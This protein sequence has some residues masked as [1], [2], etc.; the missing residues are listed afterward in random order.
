MFSKENITSI[1]YVFHT[2]GMLVCWAWSPSWQAGV[3]VAAHQLSFA[4]E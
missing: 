1:M 4:W 2:H 3:L